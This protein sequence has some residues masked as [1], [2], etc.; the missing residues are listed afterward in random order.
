MNDKKKVMLGR[1]GR[2]ATRHLLGGPNAPALK[3]SGILPKTARVVMQ[4]GKVF[5]G[6][7]I[8]GKPMKLI[9]VTSGEVDWT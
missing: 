6:P 9:E 1:P 3:S 5:V 2:A 8:A 4:I 7:S